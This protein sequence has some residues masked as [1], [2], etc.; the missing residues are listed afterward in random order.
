MAT[1]SLVLGDQR[2]VVECLLELV[3]PVFDITFV[4]AVALP[5]GDPLNGRVVVFF[6]LYGN[7]W[8]LMQQPNAA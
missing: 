5:F 8:N 2:A 7:K 3:Q 1:Q 6:D 4:Q